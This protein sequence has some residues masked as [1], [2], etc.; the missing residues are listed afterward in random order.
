MARHSAPRPSTVRRAVLALTTAGIGLGV[1]ATA[2]AADAGP[3]QDPVLTRPVALGRTEP[4]AGAEAVAGSARHVAGP[5]EGLK[6]NPL[7]GTGVDP[8]DNGVGTQVADFKPVTSRAVTKPVA[9]VPSASG[10]P[11]LGRFWGLLHS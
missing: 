11:L 9:Q 4:R 1:G 10:I 6:P 5:V 3:G 8:L 7:A 2:T